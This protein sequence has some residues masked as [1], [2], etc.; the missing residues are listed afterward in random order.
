M[1][2]SRHNITGK[3]T[4]L[5]SAVLYKTSPFSVETLVFSFFGYFA[6]S[7]NFLFIPFTVS[8]P[9]SQLA[10][11]VKVTTRRFA[12][13]TLASGLTYR[14]DVLFPRALHLLPR[15]GLPSAHSIPL[16]CSLHSNPP[17]FS[18][19]PSSATARGVA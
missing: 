18:A 9:N 17:R 10:T 3:E 16:L 8:S 1:S 2:F 5:I 7:T 11:D 6:I 19:G 13:A 12:G 4:V 14:P 15:P